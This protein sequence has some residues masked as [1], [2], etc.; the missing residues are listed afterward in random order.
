MKFILLTLALFTFPAFAQ[1]SIF[2]NLKVTG[3]ISSTQNII[4]GY[5][6][7]VTSG[8]NTTLS[9]LSGGQQYFTGSTTQ[10]VI[11]PVVS[12]LVLGHRYEVVNNS[13]GAVTVNSSGGNTLQAMAASTKLIATVILT[14]GTSTA[15]WS[16]QYEPIFAGSVSSVAMSV[17]A[18]LSIAGSP[19]TTSGTLAVSFSGTALPVANGGTGITSGTS[20]GILAYTATGTLASSGALTASQLIKGGGAGVAPSTLAAGSQFQPLVMGATTPGYAA[21]SLNQSAAVTGTLPIANGGT[22]N[23]SLAVTA[24]GV[25]YTDGSKF[26]NVGAG[27]SGNVLQSNGASPPTWAAPGG[28]TAPLAPTVQTFLP[29]GS[30][31]TYGLSYYFT[32]ASA[33]ATV[34][35]TYTNNGNT[36]TVT[37]TIVA[38]TTLIASSSGAPTSSGTLT[39]AT[40]TG[41]ATIT[42]SAIRSPLYLHVRAIGGGGGGA[43]VSSATGTNGGNTTFGSIITASGG[44]A[45]QGTGLGSTGGPASVTTSATVIQIAA[46][47]G[48]G[49]SDGFGIASAG[50]GGNGCYSPFGGGGTGG[51]AGT[52]GH[53][54][55]ANT[56][57][58]GGG[59]GSPSGAGAAASGAC[60]GYVEAIIN[61]P[62]ATYSYAVGTGGAGA[63]ATTS[64][65][66]GGSGA[67]FVEEHYQ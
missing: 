67:I 6:T 41:D 61:S 29:A 59:G 46:I 50:T 30:S 25:I 20:G 1:Q 66:N 64:G 40:G 18:F 31:G 16:W 45:G 24:G 44:T 36:F 8:G 57:A 22:N 62:L 7:T 11:L 4:N 43:G 56:G 60:G 3:N 65:G 35:A 12:T 32:V 10:T 48:G 58:G 17:P 9:V 5:A 49:G 13:S 34:G 21:L 15:S 26:V 47:P 38:A 42:F 54:A 37:N 63:S 39:K 2:G 33:N 28:T 23:G 51:V 53:N 27:S 14:S 52:N 19:I 55:I